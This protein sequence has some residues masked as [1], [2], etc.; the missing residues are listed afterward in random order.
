M[1]SKGLNAKHWKALE[2][3]EEGALSL[4]EI[5]KACG[6]SYDYLYDLYQC[7]TTK[8]GTLGELFKSELDK[9]TVRN[10]A[11]IRILVKDNKKLALAKMNDYLR[12]CQKE[13]PTPEL[14]REMATLLNSL[15]KTAGVEINQLNVYKGLNVED[16][17]NEFKRLSA[18]ARHALDGEGVSRVGEG[19]SGSVLD[20][21]RGGDSLPEESQDPILPT[22]GETK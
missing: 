7:D 2:L 9:I 6:L 18:I 22:D 8:T 17:R 16:L 13:K 19:G 3:I 4:K 14:A 1:Q 5:A 15:S 10:S 12:L 11:K 21:F 20:T